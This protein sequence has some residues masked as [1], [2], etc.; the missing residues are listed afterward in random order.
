MVPWRATVL[1]ISPVTTGRRSNSIPF[2]GVLR[3]MTQ[4]QFRL[5]TL[6]II[7][8]VAA[9]GSWFMVLVSTAEWSGTRRQLSGAENAILNTIESKG[10]R[11]IEGEFT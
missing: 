3:G 4:P 9:V 7:L 11:I 10:L 5:R 8:T 6:F 1:V 2:D